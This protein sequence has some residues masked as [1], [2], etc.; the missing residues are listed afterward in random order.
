MMRMGELIRLSQENQ[1][2]RMDKRTVRDTKIRATGQEFGSEMRDVSVGYEIPDLDF[3]GPGMQLR[4]TTRQN[5]A[6][7]KYP[8]AV[9]FTPYK[10]ELQEYEAG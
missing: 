1:I 2:L 9:E 8:G 3:V 10:S 7:I 4:R 5:R 6:R